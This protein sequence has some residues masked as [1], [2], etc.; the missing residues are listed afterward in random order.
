MHFHTKLQT[1]SLL[2]ETFR[3]SS[4]LL[5]SHCQTVSLLNALNASW[6]QRWVTRRFYELDIWFKI[7]QHVFP[8]ILLWALMLISLHSLL[9]PYFVVLVFNIS[10]RAFACNLGNVCLDE[11]CRELNQNLLNTLTVLLCV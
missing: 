10:L 6:L 7:I 4:L 5:L 2:L 3:S 9:L 8:F 11:S 1:A